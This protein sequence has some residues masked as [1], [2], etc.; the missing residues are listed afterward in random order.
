M[1]NKII[2]IVVFLCFPVLTI[3]AETILVF[4]GD[5]GWVGQKIVRILKDF[6]HIV[7]N[8]K[9][10]LENRES[11]EKE[12]HQV[13]PDY[14]INSAGIIGKPTVDWCENHKEE[15]LRANVLGLLNLV[16]IAFLYNIHVTNIATGCIY[17]YNEKHPLGSG[18]GFTEEEEPNFFG[19]F[20]SRSKIIAEKLILSY[21][22]VLNLRLRMPISSDL[23][24][25]SFI[26]KIIN[27]KKLINIPNSMSVLEDLLPLI[28]DMLERKLVGNYNFVNPGVI[29]HNQIIELYKQYVDPSHEY[30]NFSIE[31]QNNILKVPRSNCE[32][33]ANKLLKEFPFIPS[34]QNSIINIFLEIQRKSGKK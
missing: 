11:V 10:R 17:Q 24:P 21:P 5:T 20:Y 9:S 19:S 28:P 30:E 22:N 12:I 26:G 23:S 27:Y 3:N 32:L 15:T 1:K 16:D 8:A 13:K 25:K 34:I 18:I 33:S 14:I 7:Y 4:G 31:E 29:S 6:G 2:L